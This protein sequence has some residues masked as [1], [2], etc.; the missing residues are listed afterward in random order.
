MGF[1]WAA[2]RGECPTTLRGEAGVQQV[3][4]SK[5]V[6][7]SDS[8]GLTIH[9]EEH[10][11]YLVVVLLVLAGLGAVAGLFLETRT[12]TPILPKPSFS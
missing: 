4:C 6:S 2:G 8:V 12:E 11:P 3:S 1:C 7:V 9:L 10:M 5:P